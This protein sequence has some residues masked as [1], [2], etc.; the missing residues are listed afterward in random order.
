MKKVVLLS[1]LSVGVVSM[2]GLAVNAEVTEGGQTA[3]SKG[4]A[5]LTALNEGEAGAVD[6]EIVNPE[7]ENPGEGGPTGQTGLLT[8]DNVPKFDFQGTGLSG[9]FV[10]TLTPAQT[11]AGYVKNV[12]VSDR[13]GTEAGW[14]L[15]LDITPFKSDEVTLKGA[16][17]SLPIVAEKGSNNISEKDITEIS[18][19]NKVI[20]QTDG[21]TQVDLL[22]ADQGTGAGTWLGKIADAKLTIADGNIAGTYTSTFTWSLAALPTDTGNTK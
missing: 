15:G 1:L 3:T 21:L 11:E 10:D 22:K 18:I 4:T 8:I 7:P 2:G 9:D 6:P 16:K 17:L 12:Q 14:S 5:T 13:R 20:H 19:E